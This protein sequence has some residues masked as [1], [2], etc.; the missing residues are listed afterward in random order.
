MK[1]L[2]VGL[3]LSS[4]SLSVGAF[5]P[6]N[7]TVSYMTKDTIYVEDGSN[8]IW[9]TKTDCSYT[10]TEKSQVSIVPLATRKVR[11]NTR[12]VIKVDDQRHVCRVVEVSKI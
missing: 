8:E 9:E 1:N 6:K 11:E 5:V 12:L 4:L 7:S 10:L 3:V 2:I